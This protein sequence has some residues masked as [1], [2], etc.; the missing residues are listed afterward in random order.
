MFQV[1][2]RI[3][4]RL[5]SKKEIKNERKKEYFIRMN[6]RIKLFHYSEHIFICRHNI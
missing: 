3:P 4:N 2:C 6:E 1:D 5:E